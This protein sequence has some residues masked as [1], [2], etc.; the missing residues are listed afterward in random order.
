MRMGPKSNGWC[1]HKKKKG[2]R[3]I[4]A[5]GRR[6]CG[7]RGRDESDANQRMPKPHGATGSW[8]RQGGSSPKAFRGN[9]V[10]LTPDKFL[11]FKP[12]RLGY[13]ALGQP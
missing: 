12:P 3:E 8:R 2:H 5:L 4:E 10:L 1:P 11:L 6:P 7:D 9:T 13:F